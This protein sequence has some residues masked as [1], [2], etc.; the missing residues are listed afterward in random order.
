MCWSASLP[1]SM[2]LRA[3][4]GPRA[5]VI[6]GSEGVYR[7]NF[8]GYSTVGFFA[9]MARYSAAAAQ[10]GEWR[11]REGG[12]PSACPQLW[13]FDAEGLGVGVGIYS[14]AGLCCSPLEQPT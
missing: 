7:Y 12:G 5:Q 14:S 10:G 1:L 8:W 6:P 4:P 13:A 9:P 2:Q 3:A 11:R